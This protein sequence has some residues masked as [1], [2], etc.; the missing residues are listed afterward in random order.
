MSQINKI[1]NNILLQLKWNNN[2]NCNNNNNNKIKDKVKNH[3]K[4]KKPTMLMS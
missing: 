1:I 4:I 2:N 3:Q